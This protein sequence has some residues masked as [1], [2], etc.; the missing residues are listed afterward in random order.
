MDTSTQ[1]SGQAKK[2]GIFTSLGKTFSNVQE[3][4]EKL[5][6]DMSFRANQMRD[7]DFEPKWRQIFS[8]PPNE[9]LLADFPAKAINADRVVNGAIFISY[10]NISFFSPGTTNQPV[11]TITIPFNMIKEIQQ[12]ATVPSR[13]TVPAVV[14]CSVNPELKPKVIQIFTND[15]LVHQFIVKS[16]IFGRVFVV[17]DHAYRTS[18]YFVG[19]APVAQ[20]PQP[21][22]QTS[23]THTQP[24]ANYT[25]PTATVYTPQSTFTQ[26]Q[27]TFNQPQT[28]FSQ[29]QATF[30]QPQSATYTQTQTGFTQPQ[31]TTYTPLNSVVT[32][33]YNPSDATNSYSDRR[34]TM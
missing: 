8:L 7:Q 26:P 34:S 16:T 12:G 33:P 13:N 29:P 18:S 23:Y 17:L 24:Q 1:A 14:S 21:V 20:I 9:R 4:A 27:T 30:T 10:H 11:V 28:A 2:K 3:Q 15:N 25:Q 31:T 5:V 32:E 6:Q 22:G 19:S